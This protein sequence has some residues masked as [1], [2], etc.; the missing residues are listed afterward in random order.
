MVFDL[1]VALRGSFL[2]S[3]LPFRFICFV[4]LRLVFFPPFLD[5]GFQFSCFCH[6][7]PFPLFLV[8]FPLSLFIHSSNLSFFLSF[9]YASIYSFIHSFIFPIYQAQLRRHN[10]IATQVIDILSNLLFL[11][12]DSRQIHECS[13]A[14]QF[15]LLKESS[16]YI[17]S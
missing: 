13:L 1:V 3:F 6:L 16:F 10:I 8:S 2:V 11:K 9:F 14:S 5:C 17:S 7:S 15:R 12:L 4:S